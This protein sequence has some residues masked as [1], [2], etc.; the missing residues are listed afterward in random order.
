MQQ[1]LR[2]NTP[3]YLT[4]SSIFLPPLTLSLKTLPI[5]SSIISYSLPLYLWYYD[6]FM[7]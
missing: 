5:N 2:I 1:L 4:N 7:R 6:G 3:Q